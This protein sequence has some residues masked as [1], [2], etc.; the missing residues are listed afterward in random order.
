MS[1]Q[2]L[3]NRMNLHPNRRHPHVTRLAPRPLLELGQD[4][5]PLRLRWKVQWVIQ[6]LVPV[7]RRI[8]EILRL[9]FAR[10][11]VSS[12]TRVMDKDLIKSSKYWNGFR[13][14]PKNVD[15]GHYAGGMWIRN[16]ISP[17]ENTEKPGVLNPSGLKSVFENLRYFQMF[18]A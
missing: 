6:L 12:T 18:P 5:V 17:H 15:I 4:Q 11:I 8:N 1:Q 14:R 16:V 7:L 13:D 3:R 10:S 2:T 9:K